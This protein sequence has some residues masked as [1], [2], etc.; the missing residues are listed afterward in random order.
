MKEISIFKQVGYHPNIVRL[1]GYVTQIQPCCMVMEYL[2]KADLKQ[3]L[4]KIKSNLLRNY[5]T[6]RNTPVRT[7]DHRQ[8]RFNFSTTN[9]DRIAK[10]STG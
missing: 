4:C 1:I 10:Y 5:F 8:N 3:Y 9:I 7:P 6:N 2:P